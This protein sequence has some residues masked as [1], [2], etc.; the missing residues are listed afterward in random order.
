MARLI[1]QGSGQRLRLPEYDDAHMDAVRE[2]ALSIYGDLRGPDRPSLEERMHRLAD[3]IPLRVRQAAWTGFGAAMA[4]VYWRYVTSR[5][6]SQQ[7]QWKAH[8]AALD[9]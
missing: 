8:V 9:A 6:Q 1:Q 7:E 4:S 5:A 2:A 3:R